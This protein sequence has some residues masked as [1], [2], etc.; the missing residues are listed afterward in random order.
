M[1]NIR[2]DFPILQQTFYGKPLAYLDNGSTTQKPSVVIEAEKQFYQTSNANVH[3]GV[4]V[5]SEKATAAYEGAR[6]TVQHFINAHSE[7]EIIF[8]RGTT[9]SINLVAQSFGRHFLKAGD[10]VMISAM[11]HHS[12]IVPWQMLR[13]QIGIVLKI[14]P[15][16]TSGELLLDEYEKLLTP[17]TKLV[18]IVHVSNA[19]GTVNPIKKMI[20]MAR[21]HKALVLIDAAQSI[22]HMPIDVQMLDCDFLVFSSHKLYGPT[23][24]GVLYGKQALLDQMP[25]WQGGGDM[26][27]TVSFEKTT[28]ADLPMKFEAGTPN[29]AGVV[30]LGAAIQYVQKLGL[31][32]IAEYEHQLLQ[33]ANKQLS[34]VPGIRFVGTATD[35][36]GVISFMLEG[37]HPHDI[38]SIL[39]QQGVAVRAGHHC[40]MPVMT[41][42]KVPAT[43]RASL[44]MYNNNQDIEQL[45]QGLTAVRELFN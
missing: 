18:S 16:N 19:L 23:G 3:R 9:E 24:V 5:L 1:I 38:A 21:Q 43:V 44:A 40:T 17:K 12:N 8:T 34:I 41:F 30:G 32:N 33:E 7:K 45:V 22:A 4:Y 29:I 35:K 10:E 6:K 2:H 37:V 31:G 25:P 28:Y 11:E 42:F 13:D 20:D 36:V 39:D 15:M 27:K 14:I 26:I